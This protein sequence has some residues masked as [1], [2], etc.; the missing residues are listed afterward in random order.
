MRLIAKVIGLAGLTCGC[1]Q[2]SVLRA[3]IDEITLP[4]PPVPDCATDYRLRG[5]PTDQPMEWELAPWFELD[6]D[7]EGGLQGLHLSEPLC[8]YLIPNG[9]L[10]LRDGRGI[11]FFFHQ[12]PRWDYVRMPDTP[13][14]S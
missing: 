3:D 7:I 6:R 9:L 5:Q 11:K 12:Y 13:P 1:T 8:F 2:N 14:M 4:S 10:L